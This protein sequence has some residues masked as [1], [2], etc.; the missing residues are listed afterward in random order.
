MDDSDR[1][2]DV[3]PT[4]L[5]EQ[6]R[7]RSYFYMLLDRVDRARGQKILNA[8]TCG[9]ANN[10][11]LLDDSDRIRDVSQTRFMEQIRLRSF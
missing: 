5:M 2:R 9:H 6:V 1:I 3:S 4:R 8:T 11:N 10:R 7:L